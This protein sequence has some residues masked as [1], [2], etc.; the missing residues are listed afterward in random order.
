MKKVFKSIIP[1]AP[2][3]CMAF[4]AIPVFAANTT[5]PVS[6]V[7][8]ASKNPAP[9]SHQFK[10]LAD[11]NVRATASNSGEIV[12]WLS[13]GDVVWLDPEDEGVSGWIKIYGYNS[14]GTYVNGY[15][16]SRYMENI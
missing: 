3:L 13:K 4:S 7:T 6:K 8:F 2:A 10:A 9:R 15:V 16:A 5:S 1:T 14:K 11:L 12:G